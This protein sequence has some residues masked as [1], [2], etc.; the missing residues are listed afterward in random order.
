MELELGVATAAAINVYPEVLSEAL[1]PSELWW[2]IAIRGLFLYSLIHRPSIWW[3][4]DLPKGQ[5]HFKGTVFW[6]LPDT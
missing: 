4:F 5:R 2:H 3:S 6:H 1:K